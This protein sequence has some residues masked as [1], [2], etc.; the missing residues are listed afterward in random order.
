M[1]FYDVVFL[2]FNVSFMLHQLP[3]VVDARASYR[4]LANNYC[5]CN[6]GHALCE[7]ILSQKSFLAHEFHGL[8]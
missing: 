8:I 5:W 6:Q 7:I 4:Q 2:L 3:I 1:G